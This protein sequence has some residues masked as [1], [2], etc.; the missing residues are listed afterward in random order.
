MPPRIAKAMGSDDVLA[1]VFATVAPRSQ[2]LSS[3]IATHGLQAIEAKAS[4]P[5]T[6]SAPQELKMI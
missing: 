3:D 2:M 4:L 5:S 1:R 6:S